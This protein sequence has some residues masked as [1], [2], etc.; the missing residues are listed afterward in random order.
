MNYIVGVVIVVLS[1]ILGIYA[2]S[3][4]TILQWIVGGLY[5]GYIAANVLK[6]YWWRF[7]ANGF[8]WGMIA[9]TGFALMMPVLFPNTLALWLFPVLFAI[10]L[11]GSIAGTFAAPP[12]EMDVLKN[13]YKTVRPWGFWQP[14]HEAVVAENPHFEANKNFKQ[15]MFNVGYRHCGSKLFDLI[16][17]IFYNRQIHGIFN[18]VIRI[19]ALH[20]HFKTYL[21]G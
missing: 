3:V 8:A 13:F 21:V 15:D 18:R 19:D 16:A 1:I 2:E 20:C 11:A 17:H 5:A 9:G 12:T 4:N 10:S 6:W 7:N 14:V